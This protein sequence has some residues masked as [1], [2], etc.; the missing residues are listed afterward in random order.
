L[1]F[2]STHPQ[3]HH[4]GPE[5]GSSCSRSK[6]PWARSQKTGA[7][8]ASAIELKCGKSALLLATPL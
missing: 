3:H 7:P 2:F 4:Y 8:C 5:K 6:D 1:F